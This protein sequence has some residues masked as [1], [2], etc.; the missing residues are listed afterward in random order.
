MLITCLMLSHLKLRLTGANSLIV[1][2]KVNEMQ[3]TYK[4][5]DFFF[6]KLDL[7][8]RNIESWRVQP[9]FLLF[10]ANK[11]VPKF[12]LERLKYE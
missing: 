7:S 6:A 8:F 10:A 12:T 3:S 2:H 1:S 9:P 11:I 4:S 5:N